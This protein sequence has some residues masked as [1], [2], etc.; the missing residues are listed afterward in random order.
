MNSFARTFFWRKNPSSVGVYTPTERSTFSQSGSGSRSEKVAWWSS[1]HLGSTTL[2]GSNPT[3][4]ASDSWRS[5]RT[6]TEGPATVADPSA[7]AVGRHEAAPATSVATT[8]SRA[9]PAAL[10]LNFLISHPFLPPLERGSLYPETFRVK[11]GARGSQRFI[12]INI[13]TSIKRCLPHAEI[14]S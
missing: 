2:L 13:F 3:H 11:A 9:S 5:V 7:L 12:P 6:S 1:A 8:N 4:W 10:I 14:K